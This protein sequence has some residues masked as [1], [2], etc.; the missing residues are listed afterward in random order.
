MNA[1]SLAL[2]DDMP[3]SS[4]RHRGGSN[5]SVEGNETPLVGNGERQKIGIRDLPM[6]EIVASALNAQGTHD[7][8]ALSGALKRRYIGSNGI[9]DVPGAPGWPTIRRLSACSTRNCRR[10]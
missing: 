3:A 6:P 2:H 9:E 7:L 4:L 8:M 5:A 1:S 10:G